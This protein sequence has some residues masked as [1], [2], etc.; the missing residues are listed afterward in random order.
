MEVLQKFER[1]CYGVERQ[2]TAIRAIRDVEIE[3]LLIQLRVLRSCFSKEQLET[4]ALQFFKE[5]LPN[6]SVILNEKDGEFELARKIN[7]S[8]IPINHANE[9]NTRTSFLQNKSTT[10]PD[11]AAAMPDISGFEFSSKSVKTSFLEAANLHIPDFVLEEPTET[12]ML[13]VQDTLQTPG[14]NNQRLSV[15]MTPKTLRLPKPGEMLLSVHGSPL[16][17]YKE[18]NMEVIDECEEA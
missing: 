1:N 2:I 12:Q 4:P 18:E 10:Y 13:G 7:V 6:L 3:H 15:G 16:G 8:S 14:V 5:N 17:V 9:K 11:C